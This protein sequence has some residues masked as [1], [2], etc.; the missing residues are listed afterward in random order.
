MELINS[1]CGAKRASLSK[2][3]L[4]KD[5]I[6]V[7]K[8]KYVL[9]EDIIKSKITHSQ[10]EISALRMLVI[11][12]LSITVVGLLLA[13]PLYFMGKKKRATAAFKA[14]DG[15]SFSVMSNSSKET[16]VL[17]KYSALG[18]FD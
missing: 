15:T 6:K 4:G 3:L 14:K 1:S 2:T 12:L 10:N 18:V 5:V 9:A 17:N 16:A 13:I 7:G 8:Q 11:I